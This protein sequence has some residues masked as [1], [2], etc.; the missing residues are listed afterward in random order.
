MTKWWF[1]KHDYDHRDASYEAGSGARSWMSQFFDAEFWLSSSRSDDRQYQKMLNQLQTSANII[2]DSERL[3]IRWAGQET[4]NGVSQKILHLSPDGLVKDGKVD[5]AKVDALTGRVYLATQLRKNIPPEVA[6]AYDRMLARGLNSV[7]DT[8]SNQ[9]WTALETAIARTDVSREWA[10]FAPYLAAESA[11]ACDDKQNVQDFLD[12]SVAQP[13]SQAA[14]LGIAWNLLHPADT[15]KIPDVYNGVIDYAGD[16]LA[17]EIPDAKRLEVA[18]DIAKHIT[19]TF[20]DGKNYPTGEEPQLVE[21]SMFS[22][23]VATKDTSKEH[24]RSAAGASGTPGGKKVTVDHPDL[25]GD[26][27]EYRACDMVAKPEHKEQYKA[28]VARLQAAIR[29]IRNGMLFQNTDMRS[30]VYGH[31]SGDVDDGSL[32]KLFLRDDHVMLRREIRDRKRIGITLLVD[33]S[34]SMNRNNKTERARDVVIT[35]LESIGRMPGIDIAVVGH[36]SCSADRSGAWEDVQLYDYVKLGSRD[37]SAVMLTNHRSENLDSWAMMHTA[38]RMRAEFTE[39][40]RRLMFVISDGHPSG[41]TYG[42]DSARDHMKMVV[43]TFSRT[44]VQIYGIGVANAFDA[45]QAR[46]MYG[47]GRAVVLSDVESSAGVIARFVQQVAKK[48]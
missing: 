29:A 28:R 11:D 22:G 30:E 34:G 36:S 48:L 37:Y 23:K 17:N 31:R 27:R 45:Y 6:E 9:I 47:E 33:E 14:A 35:L 18:R 13:S 12:K 46:Q 42:G 24:M 3:E 16:A 40:S 25:G 5:E 38:N 4:H 21:S 20:G 15:V 19:A 10:G 41:T 39:H 7:E 32:H 43:D 44:G 8:V 1:S 26:G 2:G